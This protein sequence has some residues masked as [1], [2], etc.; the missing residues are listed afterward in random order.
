MVDFREYLLKNRVA[1]TKTAPFYLHWVTQFFNHCH[2]HPEEDFT[3][4]EQ[5]T[6]LT[7]KARSLKPWQLEQASEAIEVYRLWKNR[8]ANKNN[9]IRLDTR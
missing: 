2:K 5:A 6:F 9:P 3:Q 1:N 8:Q 7:Y 4:K